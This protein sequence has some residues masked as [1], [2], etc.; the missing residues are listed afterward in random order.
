[1]SSPDR[2]E[3]PGTLFG[4]LLR[5]RTQTAEEFSREAERFAREHGIRATLS[6]RHVQRLASGVRADG[7]P[8]G[9]PR[10][11][12]RRLLEE[13]FNLPMTRLLEPAQVP[14]SSVSGDLELQARIAAGRNIDERTV[15][16]FHHQLD[17]TRVID[18]RLGAPALLGQLRAQ[19]DQMDGVLDDVLDQPTQADLAAVLV[20]A[21]AL[22]GW[23]SL[24]QGLTSDA[25]TYYNR[26]IR[27]ARHAQSPALEA[28]ARAGQAVVLL[29]IG[30]TQAAVELTADVRTTAKGRVPDL[31]FSWLSAGYG[32]ACAANG[33]HLRS[34]RAFDEAVRSMPATDTGDTPYLV[35]DTTHLS[36]WRGNALA[37]LGVREAIGVLSD[38]LEQ[39]D[40]SF[41]RAETML[42]VDLAQVFIATGEK[43]A[44]AAHM[45]RARLLAAQ[46]GSVRQGKRLTALVG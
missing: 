10:P 40:R 2:S 22:A 13:M 7:R 1:M 12:T 19:I 6:P 39:L 18:R 25:W 30:E 3:R 43:D 5:Q 20:D 36:R 28:Y 42:R 21:S 17:I 45:E 29:D 14:V 35:F 44:A 41:A 8:L 24:D 23:Q 16:L 32:E 9:P 27:A 34:M 46:V 4:E 37:R 15:R 33:E 11:V 26:A 31:L 38:V